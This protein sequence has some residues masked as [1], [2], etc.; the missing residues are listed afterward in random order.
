[1]RPDDTECRTIHTPREAGSGENAA[2]PGRARKR[3]SLPYRCLM[4]SALDAMPGNGMQIDVRA[5]GTL[6]PQIREWL[7]E[8]PMLVDQG[9]S[10]ARRN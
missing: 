3:F 7:C 1:M 8:E 9:A 5:R 4:N 6:L 10:T 2:D